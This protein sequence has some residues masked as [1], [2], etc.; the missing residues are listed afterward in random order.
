MKVVHIHLKII[1]KGT[2]SVQAESHPAD[3]R[4]IELLI[5]D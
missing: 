2:I 3:F 5:P 1:S 4:K